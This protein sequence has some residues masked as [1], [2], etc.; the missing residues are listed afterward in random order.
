MYNKYFKFFIKF[1]VLVVF[2][3]FGCQHKNK[4]LNTNNNDIWLK[5]DIGIIGVASFNIL[6]STLQDAVKNKYQGIIIQLDTPGGALEATRQMVKMIM[7]SPVPII[8]WVG[9]RGSRAAS[10][11]AFITLASHIAAMASGTNI[12]A[13][14]P[15]Q[16]T[17]N[18]D[19]QNPMSQKIENDT[20]AFMESIAKSTNRNVEMAVSFVKV[21]TSITAEE[22]LQ[23]NVIDIIAD[24]ISELLKKING[25]E[26]TMSDNKKIL[27]NTQNFQVIEF[28][29][30]IKQ[31]FLEIL[32]NPN[33]FYLLFLA[34]IIGLGFELTHPG[35][36]FPG[37]L[38]SIS[39]IL[40]LISMSV[41]PI[42]FG[43]ILLVLVGIGLLVVE[44]FLPSFGIL[45]IGG[46]VAFALGSFLL[47]DSRTEL[48]LTISWYVIVPTIIFTSLLFIFIGYLIAKSYRLKITSGQENFKGLRGV[49]LEDF[50][51]SSGKV[52]IRGEIWS[53]ICIDVG[54]VLKKNDQVVV[55]K[56]EGLVLYIRPLQT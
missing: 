30:N 45:G 33:L 3:Y 56:V 2:V 25:R 24:D 34:G 55:E 41:L 47:I 35:T 17:G 19:S 14:H 46:F 7:S 52:L 12:G 16:I 18:N 20:V 51:G 10:A 22:A 5:V 31:Q 21:S 6:E 29:K 13:A 32:S 39:L 1:L 50:N 53:A 40:A 48:G 44:M 42:N 9:P 11:G 23:H 36:I 28:E 43:A 37:V 38:G 54:C 15:V 27:L 8:V 26:I 4:I 49:V